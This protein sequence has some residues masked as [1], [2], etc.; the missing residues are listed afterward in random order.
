MKCCQTCGRKTSPNFDKSIIGGDGTTHGPLD[1]EKCPECNGPVS[2]K[3]RDCGIS[4]GD[5]HLDDCDVE[6]CSECGTQK[7]S[8]QCVQISPPVPWLGYSSYEEAA[9]R[10]GFY[11]YWDSSGRGDP[12]KN[13]GWVTVDKDHPKATLDLNRVLRDCV[14]NKMKRKWELKQ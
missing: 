6:T 2:L 5:Y 7:L 13:Y 1:I 10:L 12:D 4:V 14:W 11:C 9:K 3:C 8:C